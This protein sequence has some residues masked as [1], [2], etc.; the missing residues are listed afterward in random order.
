MIIWHNHHI[1]P[2]HDGGTDDPSNI[3]RCNL[4][5]HA[6]MHEQRYRETGNEFDNIAAKGLRSQIGKDEIIRSVL[7][8]AGKRGSAA[9]GN[10]LKQFYTNPEHQRYAGSQPKPK[11]S[12]QMKGNNLAKGNKHTLPKEQCNCGRWIAS[13]HMSRHRN[14]CNA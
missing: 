9:N 7:S 13:N 3:L 8:E 1:V 10:S 12:L 6:F 5:M 2:K 4:A 11:K 14:K